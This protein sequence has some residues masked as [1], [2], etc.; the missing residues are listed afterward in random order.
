MHRLA[1]GEDDL[2][3]AETRGALAYRPRYIAALQA[4]GEH[5]RIGRPADDG[6]KP[7]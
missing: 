4:I 3:I 5:A 2:Q 7:A 1:V 6:E